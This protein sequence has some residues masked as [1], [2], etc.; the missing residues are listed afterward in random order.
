MDSTPKVLVSTASFFYWFQSLADIN[1]LRKGLREILS[2]SFAPNGFEI[3]VNFDELSEWTRELENGDKTLPRSLWSLG[4]EMS[5]QILE[6]PYN[7]VH[8]EQLGNL[9]EGEEQNVAYLLGIISSQLGIF[10]FTV[11]PDNFSELRWKKLLGALPVGVR[12][13]VENMDP[14]KSSHQTIPELQDLL[15]NHEK[16]DVAFDICHWLENGFSADS[17]CLIEFFQTRADRISK[18]HFST[19]DTDA[20]CYQ[21]YIGI[22]KHFLYAESSVLLPDSFFETVPTNT[23]WIIEGLIPCGDLSGL[24]AE[25]RFLHEKIRSHL[26]GRH[27]A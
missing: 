19:P 11:H 27:V 1:N 5:K 10:D 7:S 2:S 24:K 15:S 9:V 21:P 6:L 12:L 25:L 16:L 14:R 17:H 22:T 13:S 20:I 4:T 8:L 26:L 23:S 18:L 3:A